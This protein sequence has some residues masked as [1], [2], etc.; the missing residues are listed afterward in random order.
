[1]ISRKEKE[2]LVLELYEQGRNF[3]EISKDLRISFRDL[4]SILKKASGEVEE[5]PLA[6][7]AQAYK[8]FTKGRTPVDVAISLNLTQPEVTQLYREYLELKNLNHLNQI[9][10][11]L[12]G[13]LEPFLKF[14]YLCTSAGFSKKHVIEL[15]RMAD[16]NL[17]G[18]EFKYN[19]IREE[20]DSLEHKKFCLQKSITDLEDEINTLKKIKSSHRVMS[21]RENEK[22]L[23]LQK[24]R[25]KLQ[26]LVEQ[27][28]NNN[29]EYLRIKLII[30][31]QVRI[32]L[33]NNRTLLNL[34]VAS[35]LHSTQTDPNRYLLL[36][37][38]AGE[39]ATCNT[40]F[41]ESY[42]TLLLED[43]EKLHN[44]MTRDVVN[45]IIKDPIWK[46]GA[47][48]AQL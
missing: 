28:E 6:I 20:A 41:M 31:E 5:Q 19:L 48:N 47:P 12:R 3:R 24:K 32:I 13:D 44:R 33:S 9:Y 17:Q 16:D 29:E 26:A 42:R 8:L 7:S 21:N 34:A 22:L 18:F 30:E 27:F 14:Y 11:D 45:K 35:V 43:A 46:I 1:L 39:K 15:L 25:E 37:Q 23:R 38:Y 2:K 4:S 10:Q 40:N 36:T